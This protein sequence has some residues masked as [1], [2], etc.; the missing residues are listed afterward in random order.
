MED[1]TPEQRL[2]LMPE[3]ASKIQRRG[4]WK[5]S[6]ILHS[7]PERTIKIVNAILAGKD[8]YVR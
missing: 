7:S 3:H 5:S 2:E 4:Y 6:D 8:G 1:M